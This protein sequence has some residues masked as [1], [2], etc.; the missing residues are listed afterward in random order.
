MLA[1]YPTLGKECIAMDI[2]SQINIMSKK[3][4]LLNLKTGMEAA[5]PIRAPTT[6]FRINGPMP[7]RM[8]CQGFFGI[9]CITYPLGF[10]N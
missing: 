9:S 1:T 10:L 2:P 5:E 8:F 4:G 7:I 6:V 3:S